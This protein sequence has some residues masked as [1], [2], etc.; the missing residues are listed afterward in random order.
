MTKQQLAPPAWIGTPPTWSAP[1]GSAGEP[2]TSQRRSIARL[3]LYT[4]LGLLALSLLA[5]AVW[6]VF[7]AVAWFL[8]QR[9]VKQGVVLLALFP[10]IVIAL[11]LAGVEV[12]PPDPPPS[13]DWP[14]P[15]AP[16]V[17][18]R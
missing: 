10:I 11:S 8:D 17:G 1:H 16:P 15:Y 7:L 4:A 9:G 5:L 13:S 12:A 6:A 2:T 3:G 14:A 18:P